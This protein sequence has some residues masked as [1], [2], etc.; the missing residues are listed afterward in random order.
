MRFVIRILLVL[1]LFGAYNCYA[2][3]Q[4]VFI[5]NRGQWPEE[6]LYF[7]E[8]QGQQYWVTRNALIID[9]YRY[10]GCI[11]QDKIN[12]FGGI[13]PQVR[14]GSVI[15][16]EFD[17]S[18]L[19]TA[20]PAGKSPAYYNYFL[21]N[22]SSRWV[23]NAGAYSSV[24]LKG[25]YKGIDLALYFDGKGL[26]HDFHLDAGA[27]P[28]QICYNITGSDGI[29]I[30]SEGSI[31]IETPEGDIKIAGVAAFSC[32]HGSRRPVG[33][34][35]VRQDGNRLSFRLDNYDSN[36]PLLIDPLIY[37]TFIGGSK[38][39]QARDIE[40]LASGE[41]FLTGT[42]L[43]RDFPTSVGAYSRKMKDT[44]SSEIFVT[45]LDSS[46]RNLLFST[47]IGGHFEDVPEGLEIDAAGYVFVAGCT[48][49][50][51]SNNFP[52]T[53][54]AWDTV[55]NGGY[56]VFILKLSDDGSH[57]EYSTY[58]GGRYDDFAQSLVVDNGGY[59]YITGYTTEGGNYPTTAA[60]YG[61]VHRGGY[62][63]FITKLTAN[64]SNIPFSTFIAGN[65]D[66]FGNDIDLDDK[67]NIYIVGTTRSTD[68]PTT[69]R[70]WDRTYND[71]IE[72]DESGD[73]F[74]SVV[75]MWGN[76]L[77]FSTY[78]GGRAKER[79]YGIRLDSK[80]NIIVAG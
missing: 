53:T 12:P 30:D 71:T 6:V 55:Y 50:A 22:D 59:A 36:K 49:G 19:R 72:T 51:K 9:S 16:V 45:K 57:L 13:A 4:T 43:S 18:F 38:F 40:I 69:T 11:I 73:I 58:I 5:E 48:G 25:L 75:D 31:N 15:K 76:R 8:G 68:F 74:V 41:V 33:C 62:D 66:D 35:F 39:D 23:S 24:C 32:N 64:G 70:A 46:G 78:L 26:R 10:D 14:K 27:D 63:A 3:E 7:A 61:K 67:G 29:D 80:E 1:F 17:G 34:R 37:S 2:V 28:S 79:A 21:G 60:A 42:T 52:V 20:E 44:N 56:D 47:Y 77:L 65:K 54:G